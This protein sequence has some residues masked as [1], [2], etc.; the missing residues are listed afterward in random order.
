MQLRGTAIVVDTVA[1]KRPIVSGS[2]ATR[3]L[4]PL[5]SGSLVLC[6]KA[7]GIVFTLPSSAPAGTYFDF[8]VSV[9]ATSN[10]YKIITAV[11]TE[12]MVG[13]VVNCDTD[14]TDT[15]A[16]WKG[17]VGSSYIALKLNGSTTGGI[18]GDSIRVTKLNSTTWL[19][20]GFMNSTG[21]V[22]T[23]FSAS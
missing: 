6:D 22:A 2:G 15:V 18:K 5:E 7:D 14:T 17:L 19:V 23:P 10:E 12:L 3:T 20:D 16:I 4:N 9:T 13:R 8:A 11:G 21:S 1:S